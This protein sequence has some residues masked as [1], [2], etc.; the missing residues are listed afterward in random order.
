MVSVNLPK[1]CNVDRKQI[2]SWYLQMN[3][4]EKSKMAHWNPYTQ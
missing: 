1:S 4:I 2:I 3:N